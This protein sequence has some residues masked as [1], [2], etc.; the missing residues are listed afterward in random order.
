MR[1]LRIPAVGIV[2][3]GVL[4]AA[5]FAWIDYT[6]KASGPLH[7][8]TL[9]ILPRGNGLRVIARQLAANGI[10][11]SARVFSF[12]TLI[13]RSARDL[14][15]GEYT[16]E[17]GISM[18]RV[19]QKLRQGEVHL[20][21]LAIPEGI[22]VE[23]IHLIVGGN[24]YLSGS[25]PEASPEGSLAPDTYFFARDTSRAKLLKQMADTQRQRL[26]ELWP[27]R[28]SDLPYSTPEEALILASLVEKETA[29]DEERGR[30]AA[31]FVNRM[32]KGIRLQSDPTVIYGL[33]G[34]GTF[35]R[36]LQQQDLR[37]D[38]PYNTYRIRGLPP[39]PIAAPGLASI[40]ATLHPPATDELYFVAN[41]KGGHDFASTL[42]EHNQNVARYRQWQ[43]QNKKD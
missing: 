3:I 34:G 36:S 9:L 4:L 30:I 2:C 11:S 17:S 21:K 12:A 19:L 39:T 35:G 41:G 8:D 37:S 13:R 15:A 26:A 14:Q 40:R 10:I 31:V 22:S 29:V 7:S 38:S 5:N 20:R 6:F 28:A 42:K 18:Q 24:L 16:F 1:L 23:K 25:L 27:D 33:V 32:R 43:R